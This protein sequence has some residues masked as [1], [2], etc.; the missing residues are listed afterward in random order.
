[1]IA[2]AWFALA[3]AL[4]LAACAGPAPAPGKARPAL[5]EVAG[6]GGA[7]G[8][9]FGTVHALPEGFDWRTATLERSLAASDE[10]LLE[11]GGAAQR[12]RIGPTFDLLAHSPGHPPLSLRL[13]EEQRPALLR[14]MREAGLADAASRGTE[15]W[16]AALILAQASEGR[17]SGGVEDGLLDLARDKPVIALEGVRDQLAIFDRLPESDQRDLLSSVVEQAPIARAEARRL[18]SE[19]R[20]GRLGGIEAETRKGLLSHPA[21]RRALLLDRNRA[22]SARIAARLRAGKRPF[23]AVGAAHLAGPDGL[24]A[25]LAAAGW[26]VRR[27]Q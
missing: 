10:L 25:L 11:I 27:V 20:L 22:W 23:V 17:Q 21:L 19:W 5:W 7:R 15:T 12:A 13:P 1:M 3:A 14:W 26:Q 9:L 8:W 24:P 18:A 6:P 16:A 2:R 4:L